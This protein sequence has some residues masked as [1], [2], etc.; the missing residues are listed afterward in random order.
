L[1]AQADRQREE[2]D[3]LAAALRLDE[4]EK[5]H[6]RKKKISL[7]LFLFDLNASLVLLPS[8][9]FSLQLSSIHCFVFSLW[10][11]W[12]SHL[13]QERAKQARITREV[14]VSDQEPSVM[15]CPLGV[16]LLK[17]ALDGDA[18]LGKN[19]NNTHLMGLA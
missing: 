2:N 17:R 9:F 13:F 19:N 8:F 7:N 18:Q 12:I 14:K 10:F 4:Q 3:S 6:C 1:F 11:Q 5:V 15:F 16:V